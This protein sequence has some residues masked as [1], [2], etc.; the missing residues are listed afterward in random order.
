MRDLLEIVYRSLGDAIQPYRDLADLCST[1]TESDTSLALEFLVALSGKIEE[2][3]KKSDDGDFVVELFELHKRTLLLA[4]PYHFESYLLYVEW[5]RNP[6]AKFYAPRR[7]ALK[8]VVDALQDLHDDKLDKLCVSLPPGTG[9]T[10]VAIFYLSWLAGK[11]PDDPN[12]TVSHSDDIVR[13]MYDEVLRI[14]EPGGEY[15]FSDVFPFSKITRT[16]A[17]KVALNLNSP[18]RFETLQFTSIGAGNAGLYRAKRLL[19]CDDLV[20]GREVGMSEEQLD[21]LWNIYATDLKQRGIGD[22]LKELLIA[23]RWNTKDVIGRLE[24]IYGDNPRVKFI[25]IPALDDNDESNFDY[26][27]ENNF[28][29]KFYLDQRDSMDSF[30]WEAIYQNNPR[31]RGGILYEEDELR[32]YLELPDGDPDAILGICDTKN[33]GTDYEFLPVGYKYGNDHYIFDCICDNGLP[34]VVEPRVTNLLIEHNVHMCRFESNNAGDRIAKDVEKAIEKRGGNT[35][36]LTRYTTANKETKIIV[37]SGWVKKHCIF[38]DKSLYKKNS[39]YGKMMKFLTS[40]SV[41]GK[42]RND[43]V[44]DGMAMYAEFVQNLSVAVAEPMARPW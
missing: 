37:N 31:V 19:Y 22:H 40:Y 7:M 14:I 42:N 23:T 11:Y 8:V 17:K 6:S 29:T 36:I 10:T 33:K 18:S 26:P 20:K 41:E 34:D 39:D 21:K 32:Y 25:V 5:N 43:D 28:S 27:C 24:E 13:G 9:K 38:K 4:A 2:K 15:L 16:N 44:P 3:I 12:L 1:I 35:V 30:D